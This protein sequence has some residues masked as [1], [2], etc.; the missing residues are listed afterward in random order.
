MMDGF[1][2]AGSTNN[3][4]S[5]SMLL[6]MIDAG[7]EPLSCVCDSFA[8]AL[9]LLASKLCGSHLNVGAARRQGHNVL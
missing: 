6:G 3:V 5:C 2:K 1:S 4:L 7:I 9:G 8:G